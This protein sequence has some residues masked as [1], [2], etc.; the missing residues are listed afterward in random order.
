MNVA[1][2]WY[3]AIVNPNCHR[4]A[5]VELSEL[6]YRVFYPQLRRWVSHARTKIAKKFPILGRYVF[7]EVHDGNFWS[8]RN[9]NGIEAVLTGDFGAPARIPDDVVFGF[10]HRYMSGEWDFVAKDTREVLDE[11]T[12]QIRVEANKPPEGARIR[13]MEG[14]FADLITTIREYTD[15]GSVKF[16]PPGA[17]EFKTIR[18]ANARAA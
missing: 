14:E 2:N 5:S 1:G 12:G 15:T 7:V 8:I 6:G 16:L 3:V 17:R 18:L 11:G 9:V 4:R 10:M 13:I